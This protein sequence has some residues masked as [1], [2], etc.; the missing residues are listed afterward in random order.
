MAN[1]YAVATGNWSNTAIWDG[2][3]LPG[4]GDVV[5]PNGF[6]VTIDQSIT[7]GELR[8]NASAPAA[9]GGSFTLNT[10]TFNNLTLVCDMYANATNLLTLSGNGTCN[11]IGS[12]YGGIQN[13]SNCIIFT[14]TSPATL[15][16]IGNLF[17]GIG[18]GNNSGCSAIATFGSFLNINVD[19]NL[20]G[21]LAAGIINNAAIWNQSGAGNINVNGTITGL[22]GAGV[23]IGVAVSLSGLV[24]SIGSSSNDNIPGVFTNGLNTNVIV[25]SVINTARSI[26]ISGGVKVNS[27]SPTWEVITTSGIITLTDPAQT[28]PP[29]ETNVRLGT[30]YGGGAYIGLL[31]VPLPSQVS[32]GIPTDNTVGTGIVTSNDFLEAIKTSS[33]PLAERL[34]NVATVQTVGDQFNSFS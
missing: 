21:G 18:S 3:T 28:N 7:V 11:I 17:G 4:V 19:G 14:T 31:A 9:A 30:S 2:G 6:T 22:G 5:R 27:V 13:A 15:N 1:R 33:D 23:Q 12:L 26:G 10:T 20:L 32:L 29:I 25:E 16:I 34:R 8:N 24:I